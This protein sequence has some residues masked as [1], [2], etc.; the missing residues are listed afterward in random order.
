MPPVIPGAIIQN[1][2]GEATDGGK[3]A[4]ELLLGR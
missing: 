1:N 4:K 3:P 2:F